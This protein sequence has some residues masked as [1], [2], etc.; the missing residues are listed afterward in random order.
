MGHHDSRYERLDTIERLLAQRSWSTGELARELEVNQSTIFRD[1]QMLESRGTGLIHDGWQYSLDHR[2]SLYTIKMTNDEMLAIFLA[3]RLLSRHSDEHN[4]HVVRAM[5]KLAD[6]L[7]TKSPQIAQHIDRAATAVRTRRTRPAYVEAL[8]AMAQ[9]WASRQKV[10]LRYRNANGQV[11]ERTF[12]PYFIEPSGIG[13]ACHVIGYDDWKSKIITLKIE[14]ISEARLTSDSYSIPENFDPQELL[15]NAWGVIWRDEG[16][17]EV[18][19]EFSA[20][21]APRVKESV[22][23]HSQQIEELALGG[24]LFH[25]YV[26]STLEIK[27]WIRQWGSDVTVVA[28]ATLREQLAEELIRQAQNYG[29]E[30]YRG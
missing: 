1:L 24:C 16:A 6:A 29:L 30:V 15:A 20:S 25:V 3:V 22:W 18:I 9:G 17:I 5:E 21:V 19:L 28:P 12:A 14:R 4:P 11:S 13:Y 10:W 26:G 23:H 2:R 7:R 8:E 27:P